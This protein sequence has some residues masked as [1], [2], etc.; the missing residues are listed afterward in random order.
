ML[1]VS[2]L[3]CVFTASLWDGLTDCVETCYGFDLGEDLMNNQD[4]LI[5]RLKLAA[6][7]HFLEFDY[8]VLRADFDIIL[9]NCI[10]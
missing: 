3:S 4:D 2:F 5:N 8:T 1:K 9:A 6:V 7:I 10:I